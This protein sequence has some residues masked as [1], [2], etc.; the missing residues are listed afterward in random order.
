MLS[1][2]KNLFEPLKNR[3]MRNPKQTA[4][5]L[6]A[7]TYLLP[8]GFTQTV[9]LY[10]LGLAN[11]A[12]SAITM[13]VFALGTVP[14]LLA[15]GFASSFTS[16]KY[17]PVF[18]RVLGVIIIMIG[19]SSIMNMMYLYGI[20]GKFLPSKISSV[21]K[22]VVLE[23]G[24]QLAY[25]S[26]NSKGYSPASF[27]VQKGIPVKWV[28]D[29]QNVFGCQGSLVAPKIAVSRTLE[30]GKN[31]IEFTPNETGRIAFSCSMGMF[32]GEF[33]VVEG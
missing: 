32:Q 7:I 1:F 14:A 27:T 10:A 20:T 33:N 22:N 28:I 30:K 24:V 17:Y 18:A 5:L 2:T 13:M 15:I 4:F 6:G 25:M 8:C 9:Q 23:N 31:V 19:L 16:S 29:G 3:F 11:P 12:Q 21:D 26:V